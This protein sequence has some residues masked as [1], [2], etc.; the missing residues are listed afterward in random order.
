VGP[1]YWE[2]MAQNEEHLQLAR[3]LAPRSIMIAPLTSTAGTLGAVVFASSTP[4]RYGPRDLSLAVELAHRAALA[5]EN[6]RLYE[7]AQRAKQMRDD[8]LG[9]VAHDVRNPLGSIQVA[10]TLLQRQL[11]EAGLERSQK[12]VENILRS[13]QRANR[14]IQ[15]LLDVTRI[16]AGALSIAREA[17]S[18]QEIIVEAVESQR[19]LATASSIELQIDARPNLPQIWADRDRL[20]QV[21]E[22]LVGNAI[23]FT[24]PGG[25][26]TVG[27][28]PRAGEVLFWVA[29]TGQGIPSE[30]LAHVFDRFWQAKKAERRGAGLGLPICKGIVEAHAGRIWVESVTGQGSTFYFTIPCLSATAHPSETPVSPAPH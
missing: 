5:I 28:A 25:R 24:A 17:R 6:A 8:V 14:L 13:T 22:N 18:V 3:E 27:A 4:G 12:Q 20:L 19:L 23:K 30:H 7:A 1:E 29:D 21:L 10:A 2:A 9:I 16:E 26:V 11:H 15:D